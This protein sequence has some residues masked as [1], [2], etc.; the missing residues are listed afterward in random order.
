MRRVIVRVLPVP[1]PA[2]THT[3]PRGGQD[4]LALFVVEVADEFVARRSE[5]RPTWL[6]LGRD[7][8]QTPGAP[9]GHVGGIRYVDT[10][11]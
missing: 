4:G 8:R 6:H 9:R 2:S 7:G 3:G 5:P 10:G 11:L 1:A